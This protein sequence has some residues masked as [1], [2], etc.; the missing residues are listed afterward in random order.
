M[1]IFS[2]PFYLNIC[3]KYFEVNELI[4]FGFAQSCWRIVNWKNFPY[5]TLWKNSTN[6]LVKVYLAKIWKRQLV[7]FFIISVYW[8]QMNNLGNG[9]IWNRFVLVFKWGIIIIIISHKVQNYL[10]SVFFAVVVDR[11]WGLVCIV[12]NSDLVYLLRIGS[13]STGMNWNLI[14]TKNEYCFGL[15][16]F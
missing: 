9:Q 4:N 14:V 11:I 5:Q 8:S 10:G 12:L 13:Y 16:S 6:L 3:C 7:C 1:H 2:W 15:N